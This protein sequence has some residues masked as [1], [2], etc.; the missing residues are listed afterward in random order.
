MPQPRAI[1]LGLALAAPLTTVTELTTPTTAEAAPVNPTAKPTNTAMR[2]AVATAAI[3]LLGVPY[4]YGG[5][6]PTTGFDCSGF[7]RYA[8]RQAGA[9]DLPRVSADQARY[10]Q[11]VPLSDL[12]PGDLVAYDNSR[13]NRGADHV[14]IYLGGGDV[15]ESP[16]T[17]LSVRIRRLDPDGRDRHAWGVAMPLGPSPTR[18]ISRAKQRRDVP[19]WRAPLTGTPR[20]TQ[21]YGET[22]ARY[23]SGVHTGIDYGVP[24]GTKVLAARAG[25]VAS[26]TG[27]GGAYGLTV[28]LHHTGGYQTRYAH[29]ARIAVTPGQRVTTGQV[30]GWSG[31]TGNA[32]GPHL[33]FEV[34]RN[35]AHV[36]PAGI[37]PSE[38]VVAARPAK[39]KVKA[40]KVRSV[41]ITPPA[42]Q[43]SSST[44]TV[45]VGDT[46]WG[47]AGRNFRQ[48]YEENKAAIEAAAREHGRTSSNT[49]H[50]IYP[51]TRLTVPR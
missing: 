46:L 2:H 43:A 36:N 17:G 19:T 51:G 16:R 24:V 41:P 44:R 32:T 48:A 30:V 35:G 12:R 50:W 42:R 11:R 34:T 4:R 39:P 29:L 20:V 40:P 7:I 45:K 10:G 31:S 28:V 38:N 14:G 49:G 25:V 5:T 18:P 1:A 26:S 6:S 33:H 47:M 3:R 13:R 15:I 22:S 27:P 37:V 23:A 9:P 8:Y 21:N